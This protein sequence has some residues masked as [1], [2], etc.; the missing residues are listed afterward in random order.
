MNLPDLREKNTR[1][2]VFLRWAVPRRPVDRTLQWAIVA[3]MLACGHGADEPVPADRPE[4]VPG[5]GPVEPVSIADTAGVELE[6]SR[7]ASIGLEMVR[8]PAGTFFMGSPEDEFD[9]AED[10][11][12][13]RVTLTR[14]IHVART[15]V[16]QAQWAI[17]MS[18]D[19]S[20][21]AGPDLPVEGVQWIRA[22]EFCNRLSEA[23]NLAPAYEIMESGVRW[24]V[25]SNGYRLPTEA[26][27]E[28]VARAGTT[29]P[30]HTGTIPPDGLTSADSMAAPASS[31]SLA[32][33]GE[34][35]GKVPPPPS[36]STSPV[37]TWGP[38]RWGLF[39][40]HGNVGEWCWD[41]YG[42]YPNGDVTDPVGPPW[43]M[44]RVVR[45]WP[46]TAA[47][48][49]VRSADRGNAPS[50]HG[51]LVG[52]RPV[53]YVAASAETDPSVELTTAPFAE[54][55]E[56]CMSLFM[57]LRECG[58]SGKDMVLFQWKN[59]DWMGSQETEDIREVHRR[60]TGKLE[61]FLSSGDEEFELL[62]RI[63]CDH[64][65]AHKMEAV[66]ESMQD[67]KEEIF[68]AL[69]SAQVCGALSCEDRVAC[70]Q[71]FFEEIF[72]YFAVAM[73][74][75]GEGRRSRN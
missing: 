72:P 69:E 35:V 46:Y 9:R 59:T 53:R 44:M 61:E 16:S 74:P 63:R 56:Q 34:N 23:E 66:D 26:E 57:A 67:L 17:L 6:V 32:R 15:E 43:A 33:F 8:V 24:V 60:L 64:F 40:V 13:H 18:E 1:P 25:N 54:E 75:P 20:V 41:W 2:G 39:D 73:S 49:R 51:R 11:T 38:N 4:S 58:P 29:T 55:R 68:H 10:E 3:T 52:L 48:Y 37:G 14:D 31:P 71:P 27:W 36:D 22:V 47:S 70:L 7:A 62:L 30:F 21:F 45:G 12:L 5:P 42:P 19:A 28:Y 65:S 50:E